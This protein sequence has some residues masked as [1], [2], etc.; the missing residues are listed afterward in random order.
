MCDYQSF[1][2]LTS[3]C[4]LL[5]IA[6]GSF[7]LVL[8][9]A[10][11][12]ALSRWLSGD[13]IPQLRQQLAQHPRYRGQRV[14]VTSDARSGL[15]EALVT[16]LDANLQQRAGIRLVAHASTAPAGPGLPGSIDALDCQRTSPIDYLLRVSAVQAGAG[17]GQVKLELLDV[18]NADEPAHSWHWRGAFSAAERVQLQRA[19]D[20]LVADG[21]FTTPWTAGDVDVAARTLTQQLACALRPQIKTRLGLQWPDDSA[22]SALFTDTANTSRHLLGAYPELAIGDPAPDYTLAVRVQRVRGDTWQLR[23]IGTPRHGDLA[24]VQAVTY[25]TASDPGAP[26]V[27][28]PGPLEKALDYIDVQVL[29]ATQT[30]R[31]SAGAALQVTLHIG[32]RA[33]WP[34]AY[35]F[36]LSGGHFNHCVA[37]SDYYRHDRYGHLAGNVAAGDSVVRRLLI[38]DVQHQPTPWFGTR[39]CAGF[40]DLEGFEQFA[41][42]GHKVTDFV[43]WD[44]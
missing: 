10:Q 11:P 4:L 7:P 29:D 43:R 42:Q 27:A 25:F 22:L 18:S 40:R 26:P 1:R 5:A 24:A 39:K 14:Q 13:A 16:L 15:S 17:P 33:D 19:S 38:E 32:N 30:D 23:V 34:I 20:P 21:S 9:A 2:L 36:T 44:L 35:A 8:Q 37:R 12:S 41:N 6:L 31:G 28:P 3:R